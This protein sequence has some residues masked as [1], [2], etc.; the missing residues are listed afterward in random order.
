MYS[1]MCRNIHEV[2]YNLALNGVTYTPAEEGDED[3]YFEWPACYNAARAH[4]M[5]Y[6]TTPPGDPMRGMEFGTQIPGTVEGNGIYLHVI[7]DDMQIEDVTTCTTY[8][9]VARIT[10]FIAASYWSDAAC[11]GYGENL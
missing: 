5:P 7:S 2:L 1:G 10:G 6:P 4:S 11:S 9:A 8:Q 3:G